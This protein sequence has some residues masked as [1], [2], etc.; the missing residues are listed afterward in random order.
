MYVCVC[1][2]VCIYV[3]MCVYVCVFAATNFPIY[4]FKTVCVA[5]V[6]VGSFCGRSVSELAFLYCLVGCV[7]SCSFRNGKMARQRII[8]GEVET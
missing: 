8:K 2:Y 6:V 7:L 5:A 3:C 4:V 1:M